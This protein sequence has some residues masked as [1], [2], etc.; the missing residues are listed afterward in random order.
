MQVK[1]IRVIST[2][3]Y[4]ARAERPVGCVRDAGQMLIGRHQSST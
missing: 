3:F 4:E 2:L 1:P